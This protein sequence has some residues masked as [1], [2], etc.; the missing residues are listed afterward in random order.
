[1]GSLRK[2]RKQKINKHKRRKRLKA[3]RHKKRNRRSCNPVMFRPKASA[4]GHAAALAVVLCISPARLAP[5]R[6]TS[7]GPCRAVARIGIAPA[8]DRAGQGPRGIRDGD[9][10]EIRG[11]PRCGARTLPASAAIGSTTTRRWPFASARFM[12]LGATSPTR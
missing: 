12:P 11:R 1:M 3:M 8:E 7:A 6:P 2:R 4:R 10:D 5:A 9:S